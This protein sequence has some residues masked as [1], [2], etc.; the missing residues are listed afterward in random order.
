MTDHELLELAAK[1]AGYEIFRRFPDGRI[2]VDTGKK[3]TSDW[4]PLDDNGDA[5]LLSI[6]LGFQIDHQ[7]GDE[8]VYVYGG[9]GLYASWSYMTDSAMATR[10][11]IVILAAKIGKAMP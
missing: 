2:A 8:K 4:N 6:K 1:A 11:A 5:L 10:K 9:D 3:I 7:L